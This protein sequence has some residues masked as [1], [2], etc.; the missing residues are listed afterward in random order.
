MFVNLYELGQL[1]VQE[2][3]NTGFPQRFFR[4]QNL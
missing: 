3:K 1:P 4:F 2:E